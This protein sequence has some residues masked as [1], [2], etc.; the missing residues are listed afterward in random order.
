M[1]LIISVFEEF[2]GYYAERGY[3]DNVE[4]EDNDMKLLNN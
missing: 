1:W 4:L 2:K 3:S